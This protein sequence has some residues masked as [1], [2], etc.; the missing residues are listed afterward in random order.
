[1]TSPTSVA[2]RR[3]ER[4][5]IP[6]SIHA[7]NPDNESILLLTNTSIHLGADSPIDYLTATYCISP[8][9]SAV[10]HTSNDGANA[11]RCP[12]LWRNRPGHPA[13]PRQSA[14]AAGRIARGLPPDNECRPSFRL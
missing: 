8:I 12:A 13:Y 1:M 2:L 7:P 11:P 5:A 3:R 9:T 6:F 10:G 4:F 14:F